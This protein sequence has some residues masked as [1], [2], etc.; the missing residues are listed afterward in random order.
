[1]TDYISREAAI[2]EVKRERQYTGGFSFEEERAWTVGFH[3]GISFALSDI[4]AVPAADVQP[5]RH[6]RWGHRWVCSN[7]TGYVFACSCSECGKPTYRISTIEPMPPY[8][9][10]CGAKMEVNE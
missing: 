2:E 4:A 1:M 5:V 7:M 9:P 10:N 6:G 3:Q 8:C